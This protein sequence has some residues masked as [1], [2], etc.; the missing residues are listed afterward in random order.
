MP[1]LCAEVEANAQRD[2]Y[3]PESQAAVQEAPARSSLQ[4][5]VRN[6]PV[7]KPLKSSRAGE[8]PQQTG[9]AKEDLGLFTT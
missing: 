5:P 6:P 2:P 4:V 9:E 3:L 1:K 8:W 7:V